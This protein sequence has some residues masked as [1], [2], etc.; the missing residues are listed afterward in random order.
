[1]D[2]HFVPFWIV[3][4]VPVLKV[5]HSACARYLQRFL[6]ESIQILYYPKAL[7]GRDHPDMVKPILCPHLQRSGWNVRLLV[8]AIPMPWN[9]NARG[10]IVPKQLWRSNGSCNLLALSFSR[11]PLPAIRLSVELAKHRAEMWA[12]SAAQQGLKQWS[13]AHLFITGLTRQ[14][15]ITV[16]WLYPCCKF[17]PADLESNHAKQAAGFSLFL[18]PSLDMLSVILRPIAN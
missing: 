13:S 10:L 18:V 2:R 16:R 6:C 1:M 17:C 9:I 15:C 7:F 8:R 12:S 5:L 11:A 14:I 3:S 4:L